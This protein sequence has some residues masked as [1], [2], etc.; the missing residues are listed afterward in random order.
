MAPPDLDRSAVM[1]AKDHLSS[2]STSSSISLS[3]EYRDAA[4]KIIRRCG[5]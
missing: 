5:L 4:G 1:V 2:G 3:G